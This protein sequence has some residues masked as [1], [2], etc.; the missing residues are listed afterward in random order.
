MKSPRAHG[1]G[2]HRAAGGRAI[3]NEVRDVV[4]MGDV[5]LCEYMSHGHCG[6]VK[7]TAQSL[8]AAAAPPATAEFEIVN[9]A[10]L[11]LLART[12]VRW[13]AGVDIIALPT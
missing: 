5:C 6:I 4:I 7:A 1:G 12:S 13:R 10:S 11:E 9:D 2:W 8:G 3:K